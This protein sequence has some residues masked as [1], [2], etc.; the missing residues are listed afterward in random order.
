CYSNKT[1][2]I[3][4][5]FDAVMKVAEDVLGRYM[6]DPKRKDGGDIAFNTKDLI[7]SVQSNLRQFMGSQGEKIKTFN[8]YDKRLATQFHKALK[9]PHYGRVFA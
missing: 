9:D 1:E 6:S 5:D 4:S 3:L 7:D 8:W 2:R